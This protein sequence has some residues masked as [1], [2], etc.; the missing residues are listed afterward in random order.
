MSLRSPFEVLSLELFAHRS[1]ITGEGESRWISGTV[2]R[3]FRAWIWF[4]CKNPSE[5]YDLL[6]KRNMISLSCG[7]VRYAIL[8][9]L[10]LGQNFTY[11]FLSTMEGTPGTA[12]HWLG[13]V[14]N[15]PAFML[16]GE[17]RQVQYSSLWGTIQHVSNPLSPS[18]DHHVLHLS[19]C[20]ST[21]FLCTGP[22][23]PRD[24]FLS[25]QS[26]PQ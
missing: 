9:F 19:A 18:V 13:V 20:Y 1:V 26:T 23:A 3:S 2:T 14:K 7:T 12:S 5:G 17:V 24:S 10:E 25:W 8:A 15:I 6:L 11:S 21:V 4:Y 22:N 16:T